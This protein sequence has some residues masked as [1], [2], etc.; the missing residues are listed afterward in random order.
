MHIF[1]I[2][3]SRNQAAIDC[4]KM[5]NGKKSIM[6][7]AAHHANEWITTDILM[8]FIGECAEN[9]EKWREKATLYF[10]PLVNPDGVKLVLTNPDKKDWKANAAGVDLNSNYPANWKKAKKYKF[11]QGYKKPGSRDYVGKS[12]LSEPETQAMVN[13]TKENNF[14]LTLSLHTQGEVIYWQYMDYKPE[15]AEELAKRFSEVSGYALEEVPEESSHGGYRDW[16][17]QEFNKPGFTIE[18]GLGENP[19]PITDFDEIYK[20]VA[21]ILREAVGF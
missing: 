13:F 3:K 6:F 18:C 9:Y 19:L 10:V 1:T 12:P 20:K 7:N 14:D 5:G 21:P 8:K 11:S 4:L 15:G 16:F 2:G 17:I